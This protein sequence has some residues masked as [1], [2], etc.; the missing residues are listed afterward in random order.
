M[1]DI[2]CIFYLIIHFTTSKILQLF[3][4]DVYINSR[5]LFIFHLNLNLNNSE[6]SFLI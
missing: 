2:I 6:V 4:L 5:H 3:M 1:I